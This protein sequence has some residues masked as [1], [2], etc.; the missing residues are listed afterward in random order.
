[1]ATER[2]TLSEG[3]APIA[4]RMRARYANVR[5]VSQVV[6]QLR[7]EEVAAPFETARD[8]VIAWMARRAGKSLPEDALAGRSFTLDD[9]G[10]QRTEAVAIEMPKYWAARLD[11]ADKTIAQRVWTTEVGIGQNAD[12]TVLFGARLQCVTRG[13]DPQFDPSIPR[14]VRDVASA[15]PAY[16][17]GRRVSVEPW[18]VDT[19]AEVEDLVGL[20]LD[21]GRHGH[22]FVFALPEGSIAPS[23]TAASAI[24]VARH[25]IGA[26]HVAIITGPASYL[27]SDRVGKEFSV[28][29]QAVRT[30]RPAFNP[31]IDEP[32]AHPLTMPRRIESWN[33]NGPVAFQAMLIREALRQSVTGRDIEHRLPPYSQVRTV[34]G[35]IR[36]QAE[37]EAGTSDAELLVIADEEIRR[38]EEALKREREEGQG[39]IGLAEDEKEQALE[40]AQQ[41]K[42]LNYNLQH[43]VEALE[44]QIQS[45][46]RRSTRASLPV[47]LD[48]MEDWARENL[49]GSV[50]IHNRAFQGAKKSIY[51][52]SS[53]IYQALLLLRDHYVPMR[54]LGGKKKLDAFNTACQELGIIEEAS[55]TASRWGEEGDTYFV[56]YAGQ[57][58][59]LDRHLKK[60]NARDERRC[61]RLY[62]FWDDESRQVVVGWLPSHLVTRAT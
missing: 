32:F 48:Q 62:F 37:R 56:R 30:Y 57:R 28:F 59:M 11:D 45:S 60:G 61:F 23:E 42:A 53:L 43:R 55:F 58:K 40:E 14:F 46:R 20:L 12:G 29:H 52:D 54:R 49:S 21:P 4:S 18:L 19:E 2:Q 8:T 16:L 36:R 15:V 41:Y 31:G 7:P 6:L 22:V 51:E 50:E 5:P 25:A 24:D 26:A 33:D 27:L 34:A 17:N 39:L 10:A 3:L 35:E 13:E 38:L 44:V 9:V 47:S 1:M